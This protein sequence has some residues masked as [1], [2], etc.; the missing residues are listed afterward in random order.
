MTKL[1]AKGSLPNVTNVIK[2]GAGLS[3]KSHE[4]PAKPQLLTMN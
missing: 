2:G 4:P 3:L 1:R